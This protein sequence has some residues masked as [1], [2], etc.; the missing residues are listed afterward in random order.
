MID[1]TICSWCSGLMTQCWST[2]DFNVLFSNSTLHCTPWFSGLQPLS[3]IFK[4]FSSRKMKWQDQGTIGKDEVAAAGG[5]LMKVSSF[6]N[7]RVL[8]FLKSYNNFVIVE[9]PTTTSIQLKTTSTAVG[10]DTIMTVHTPPTHHRNSPS[11][12]DSVIL[13]NHHILT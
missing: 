3:V 6:H 12:Q 11:G 7:L 10:F 4:R 8:S 1:V 13:I 9:T 2:A 5:S